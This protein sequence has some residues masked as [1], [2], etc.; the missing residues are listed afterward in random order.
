[1]LCKGNWIQARNG[2]V[3]KL[4]I[5]LQIVEVILARVGDHDTPHDVVERPQP[6]HSHFAVFNRVRHVIVVESI[7][8]RHEKC[9]LLL[10]KEL[11]AL[12]RF[13][14]EPVSKLSVNRRQP[15]IRPISVCKDRNVT[16]PAPALFENVDGL[17][18]IIEQIWPMTITTAI[19]PIEFV[20]DPTAAN[21]LVS[22]PLEL[23]HC[24]LD[25]PGEVRKVLAAAC[26]DFAPPLVKARLDEPLTTRNT[27]GRPQLAPGATRP[28]PLSLTAQSV[29]T[30][31][32]A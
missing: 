6:F 1:M 18:A 7:L 24:V 12:K 11:V 8:L 31:S 3:R 13:I 32:G 15:V 4:S 21:E 20:T 10:A 17:D 26:L 14:Q 5:Q 25:G 30:R 29:S 23:L 19:R 22:G 27:L 28:R 9:R 2:V 16:P